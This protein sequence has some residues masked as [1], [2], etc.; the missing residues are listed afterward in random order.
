MDDDVEALARRRLKEKVRQV[1]KGD[2]KE[3]WLQYYIKNHYIKL[4]FSEISGPFD[5]GYD[6]IG[7]RKGKKV[8]VEA[9]RVP[10][11][12]LSHGHK[13]EEVDVLVVMAMD[14]TPKKLLPKT[15]IVV[16]AEDLVKETHEARKA[17]AIRAQAEQEAK[18]KYY[19]DS[20][21]MEQFAGALRRLHGLLFG[22]EI[23][24]DTPEDDMM[25]EAAQSVALEYIRLYDL[26]GPVQ[27]KN[28][29]IIPRIV[30]IE[31]HILKHGIEGLS[32]QDIEHLTQWL[33]L[34][35]EE[36]IGKF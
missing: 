9:E 23:H 16:D 1:Q 12:F 34:L 4:G 15:I 33:G 28:G 35:R 2:M 8:V 22:D 32:E 14:E 3:Y 31:D 29:T 5:R 19:K 27:S 26:N 30:G 18:E 21:L 20:F 10:A 13:K 17:Y 25:R 11:N 24:E 36:Y 7:T 6:F